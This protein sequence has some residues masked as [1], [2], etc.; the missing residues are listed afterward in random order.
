MS[1]QS[2]CDKERNRIEKMN[3]FQLAYKYKR[4]G[5]CQNNIM[6]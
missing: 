6:S 3:K 1:K 4:V 5:R 2:F